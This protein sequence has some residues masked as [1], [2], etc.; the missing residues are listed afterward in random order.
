MENTRSNE[1]PIIKT[2]TKTQM[3][4]LINKINEISERLFVVGNNG[5]SILSSVL[6]EEDK[7][8]FDNYC[9]K[10]N[11]VYDTPE[12]LQ[13]A[14]EGYILSLKELQLITL[15]ISFE[16]TVTSLQKIGKAIELTLG[17]P[18]LIDYKYKPGIIGGAEIE[19]KGKYFK[20]TLAELV[21]KVIIHK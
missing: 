21:N 10:N 16:P 13:K 8:Y 19:Y 14:C 17:Y 4:Y 11:M 15:T 9:K 5:E 3:E 1:L 12:S 7:Y 20:F 2:L 6:T 18:V